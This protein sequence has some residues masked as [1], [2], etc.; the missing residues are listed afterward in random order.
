M[1]KFSGPYLKS[2]FNILSRRLQLVLGSALAIYL[3]FFEGPKVYYCE[4]QACVVQITFYWHLPILFIA[5]AFFLC[6]GLWRLCWS[7]NAVGFA[8]EEYPTPFDHQWQQPWPS[9]NTSY[10]FHFG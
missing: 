2:V 1:R 4:W 7:S 6:A 9:H 3:I 10:D 5:A 8:R